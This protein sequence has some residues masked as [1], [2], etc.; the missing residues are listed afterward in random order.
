MSHTVATTPTNYVWDVNRS[1]PVVLQDGT[2]TYVYGLNLIAAIDGSNNETY[3]MYDGLGSTTEL[4]DAV[5]DVTDTYEYDV[6]GAV[7]ASTGSSSNPFQFTG[8]QTDA[9]SDLQYLRAR[10][11]DPGTG[12]FLGR[13]P[14]SGSMAM[15]STQQP[16]AYA[17]GNPVNVTDPTGQYSVMD[18]LNDLRPVL[19]CTLPLAVAKVDFSCIGDFLN[20]IERYNA[21]VSDFLSSCQGKLLAGG[22]IMIVLGGVIF[23]GFGALAAGAFVE[24]AFETA[25]LLGV[26]ASGGGL[27]ATF[28]GVAVVDA[29]LGTQYLHGPSTGVAVA[30]P[31]QQ[32][33]NRSADDRSGGKE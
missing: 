16:Y 18:F 21:F 24:G 19:E 17:L 4:T 13:D 5:G 23:T 27:V 28:G 3:Y 14:L 25:A 11:Y 32:A 1:L 22:V 9:D 26:A 33:P 2:N 15:P 29:C 6:F 31:I 30:A 12:R 10:Y 8:Q 7:R 20:A